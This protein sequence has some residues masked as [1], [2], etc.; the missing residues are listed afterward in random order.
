V[1]EDWSLALARAR[2]FLGRVRNADGS[3]GYLADQPGRPE[4]TVLA[5]A[6]GAEE[7]WLA[8]DW[9]A[10]AELGWAAF[11]LPAVAWTRAPTLCADAL[12]AIDAFHSEPVE[13][14][15]G[16]DATLPGWSWVE[17][18][19]AWVEPTAFAVLSLR[20]SGRDPVRTAQGQALILDRQCEDGGWNYGN[21]EVYGAK[22]AGHLDATG[23]AVLALAPGPAAERGLVYLEGALERP[24]AMNLSLA[25]LAA[26]AHG[27]DPA[28]WLDRLAPR[29]GEDG[30]RGRVDLSALAAAALA[31][32]VE[33]QHAFV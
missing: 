15:V 25:A 1:S 6:A 32:G 18:T 14:L 17:H 12:A 7:S 2:D 4:A 29:L 22:L 21:P 3:W 23:W 33:G 9:L 13:G 10:G 8:R 11:L 26:A 30:A 16:F 24:S 19:A 31:V 27:R 28:P 20:R 5:A